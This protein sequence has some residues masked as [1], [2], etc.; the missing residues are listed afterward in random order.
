M[1]WFL[2][3]TV[4]L[5]LTVLGRIA[6]GK[7]A[8]IVTLSESEVGQIQTALGYS[9]ILQ[10]DSRPTSAVLGDQDAFKVEYVGNSLTLK[11]VVPGAKTNLFIFT[12]YD[13]FNFRLVTGPSAQVDYVVKVKR[14]SAASEALDLG[15]ERAFGGSDS[16]SEKMTTVQIGRKATCHS[17]SLV[18][19]SISYPRAKPWLVIHFAIAKDAS[20][21]KDSFEFKAETLAVMNGKV[22]VP[23]ETLYLE[24][25]TIPAN[26]APIRGSVLV[27]KT[28]PGN[29]RSLSLVFAPF[30]P[31]ATRCS[32]LKV[33]LQPIK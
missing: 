15:A 24:T 33:R 30:Q 13:R 19:E 18:V 1:K 8:R 27:R 32:P 28:A 21:G 22:P 23:V 14:K 7:S 2:I 16:A 26:D 5:F 3:V 29:T 10:F 9:T 12:D 4:S 20:N 31:K 17:L 11:P 6:F 25:V